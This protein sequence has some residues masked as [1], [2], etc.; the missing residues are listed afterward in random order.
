MK[1][2]EHSCL[3]CSKIQLWTPNTVFI[4]SKLASIHK[5]PFENIFLMIYPNGT[6]WAN[7]RMKLTGW[8]HIQLDCST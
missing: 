3:I 5:S 8:P 6:V 7:Y 1:V 2:Q 4:N